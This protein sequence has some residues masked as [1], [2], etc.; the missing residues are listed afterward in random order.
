MIETLQNE[1]MKARAT[2]AL[3][4]KAQN[5]PDFDRL[6]RDALLA[7]ARLLGLMAQLE[8]IKTEGRRYFVEIGPL[9]GWIDAL[10]ENPKS[11]L[12][13][14][15]RAENIAIAAGIVTARELKEAKNVE[16]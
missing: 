8:R 12:L 2:E 14:F 10:L 16:E 11:A 3:T 6:W 9:A 7:R 1:S 13:S 15:D 5:Q 4:W